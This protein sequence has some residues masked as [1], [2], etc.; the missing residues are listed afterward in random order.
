MHQISCCF[1][2]NYFVI[3]EFMLYIKYIA[4]IDFKNKIEGKF[5]TVNIKQG[6]EG[7]N[8]LWEGLIKRMISL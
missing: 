3:I 6:W 4:K 2:S 5:L 7:L 1:Y 8:T